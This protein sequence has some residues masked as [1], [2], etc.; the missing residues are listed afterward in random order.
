MPGEGARLNNTKGHRPRRAHVQAEGAGGCL[1]HGEPP[2]G[3]AHL[4]HLHHCHD[5]SS[6]QMNRAPA[7]CHARSEV[8]GTQVGRR[9]SSEEKKRHSGS[10]R[11]APKGDGG[12]GAA[13][14]RPR[15]TGS[16]AKGV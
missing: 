16:P 3:A 2:L 4:S 11:S 7:L 5:H 8:L 10:M 1:A 13:S 15:G 9:Q 6:H 12:F 14:G